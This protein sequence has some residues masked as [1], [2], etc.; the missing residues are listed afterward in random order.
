MADDGI[1]HVANQ[2]TMPLT[3]WTGTALQ[4]G[5]YRFYHS[6]TTKNSPDEV[7]AI[8]NIARG[9]TYNRRDADQK[10]T[11]YANGSNIGINTIKA[12]TVEE[13]VALITANP[14]VVEYKLATETVEAYTTAQQTAYNKLK[15]LVLDKGTNYIWT[16]TEGLNPNLQ[17]TYKKSNLLRIENIESRL[18]LLE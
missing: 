11:I 6:L 10:D 5:N 13:F 14:L 1:H 8:S 12:T 7:V 3:G 16:E 17:L 4:S 2:S 15:K 18:A 9:I